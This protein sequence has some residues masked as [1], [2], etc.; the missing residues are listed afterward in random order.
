MKR[1]RS[2]KVSVASA[3]PS[4]SAPRISSR[5]LANT[6]WRKLNSASVNFNW[7]GTRTLGM[8]SRSSRG[9]FGPS[10]PSSARL[11]TSARTCSTVRVRAKSIHAASVEGSA[12][13]VISMTC[14]QEIAPSSKARASTRSSR[15]FR[16]MRRAS[17][18]WVADIPKCLRM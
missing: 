10:P 2:L 1:I 3:P 17:F 8:P 5:T 7:S 9:R 18:P 14:D 16:A 15:S 11:R 12:T 6:F 4:P 13:R